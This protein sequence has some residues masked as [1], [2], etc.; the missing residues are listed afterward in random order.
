[1]N[2]MEMEWNGMEW[3]GM[4]GL[5]RSEGEL[6]DGFGLIRFMPLSESY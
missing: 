4:L 5:F 2:G 3:N 6:V 1:M